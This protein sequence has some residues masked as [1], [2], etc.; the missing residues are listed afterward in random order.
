MKYI[1]TRN[2]TTKECKWLDRTIKKGEF[3]F[4]YYGAT[5]GCI[6]SGGSAFTF[7]E[8]KPPFFE[9]PDNAVTPKN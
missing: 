4:A 1:L 8:N 9:L 3:V 7:V 6:S 2:V 5:Y